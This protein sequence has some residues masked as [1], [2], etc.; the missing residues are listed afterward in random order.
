MAEPVLVITGPTASGKSA[1]ALAVAEQIDGEIISMDSRQVYRGMDI[2]TAKPTT[3]ELQRVRHH[4][5]DVIDP[6]MRYSAGQF[7][8]DARN[9]LQDIR[10]RGR[11]PIISGGTLFF[12][13]ALQQPLFN[14]PPMDSAQRELLRTYLN[15]RSLDELRTWAA[16]IAGDDPLP[17]DRQRLAR[18]IEVAT[19]TGRPLS[20]W[21][22]ATP[23]EPAISTVTHV[24]ALDRDALYRRI[25]MRVHEM[26]ERGF[27]AEVQGLVA[28]GY[29]REHPG[30]NATGY[31]EMLQHVETGLPLAGAVTLTQAAS[32]RYARRQLTWI[33]T[34]LGSDIHT[35]DAELPVAQLAGRVV[36]GWRRRVA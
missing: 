15:E 17:Q 12:L 1:L 23:L 13:R 28:R 33:R 21:H 34:Q 6:D 9:W 32:R 8:R 26:V 30:M 11:T 27:V 24:M 29:G 36:E 35:L 4:G 10:A 16:R 22:R 18:L 20:D 31:A 7:A 5:L 2:G 3:A 19:L 14:E 25:D